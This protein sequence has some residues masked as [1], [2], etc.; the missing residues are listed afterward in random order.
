MGVV[1]T[2]VKFSAG[3]VDNGAEFTAGVN[4]TGGHIFP[5]IYTDHGDTGGKFATG[6][7]GAGSDLPTVL[8]TSVV[9]KYKYYHLVYIF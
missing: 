5:E 9:S 1:H 4:A 8:T 2:G 3:I 7:N 6:V